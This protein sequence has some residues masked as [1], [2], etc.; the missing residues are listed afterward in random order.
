[1]DS[2]LATIKIDV[3]IIKLTEAELVENGF[4]IHGLLK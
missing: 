4:D 2:P 1:L 3:N